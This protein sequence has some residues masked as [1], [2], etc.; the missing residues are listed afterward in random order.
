MAIKG[1]Y[2]IIDLQ[3]IDITVGG[4]GV[5]I[6]GIY[7]AIENNYRKPLL[8]SGL[9]L[10]GVEQEDSFITLSHSENT[11][12]GL[13]QFLADDKIHIITITNDDKI[14]VTEKTVT[15]A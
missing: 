4:D 5:T 2:K 8:I 15:T 9:S 14:V 6:A 1:G 7:T 13:L 3:D 11:Y 10:G 12:T